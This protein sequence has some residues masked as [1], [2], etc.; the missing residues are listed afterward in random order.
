MVTTSIEDPL[1]AVL[2]ALRLRT[3]LITRADFREPW[4]IHA[5]AGPHGIF[6]LFSEGTPL[7]SAEPGGTVEIE[8]GTIILVC[9]GQPHWVGSREDL[10]SRDITTLPISPRDGVPYLEYGGLGEPTQL[11]CGHFSFRHAASPSALAGL[12]PLVC[13]RDQH[14]LVSWALQ[15][16]A[17]LGRQLD[18]DDPGGL[19]LVERL[20]DLIITQCLRVWARTSVEGKG[21]IKAA[22]DPQIGAALARIH[23]GESGDPTRWTVSSL[24]AS[25]GMSRSSFAQRFAEVVGRPPAQYISRWRCE[26]VADVLCSEDLS[27]AQAATLAG[28]S[29][30]DAFAKAFKRHFG[31][32]PR[33]YRRSSTTSAPAAAG[34]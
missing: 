14:E 13:L 15:S 16:V 26:T 10:P 5:P 12:P 25:V 19:A 27:T 7:V 28:Y 34:R 22:T 17:A 3:G 21:W 32:S 6:H 23:A 30:E 4:R 2:K 8:P 20:T 9:Q 11:T 18:T 1:S 31:V 33:E 29:S 24:A